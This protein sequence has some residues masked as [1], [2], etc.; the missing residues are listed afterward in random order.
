MVNKDPDRRSQQNEVLNK[1]QEVDYKNIYLHKLESDETAFAVDK[2]E[3]Q[4][5]YCKNELNHMLNGNDCLHDFLVV[6]VFWVIR[7]NRLEITVLRC[8]RQEIF[9]IKQGQN[10]LFDF[11][12]L[13][14]FISKSLYVSS[15]LN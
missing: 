6:R 10:L 13:Q 9:L 8:F 15:L 1:Q 7:R 3:H 4:Y 5:H 11:E 14:N 2:V 12:E